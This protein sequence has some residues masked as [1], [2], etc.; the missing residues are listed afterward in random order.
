M[1]A[2]A[3]ISGNC[4]L[5]RIYSYP[6]FLGMTIPGQSVSIES[7]PIESSVSL[8]QSSLTLF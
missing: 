6:V 8:F 7:D 3:N 5:V 1:S 4:S 2:S